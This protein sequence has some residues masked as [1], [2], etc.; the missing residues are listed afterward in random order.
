M[1][2]KY[3]KLGLSQ[4]IRD[5]LESLCLQ[6]TNAG[7]TCG[8]SV[9]RIIIIIFLRFIYLIERERENMNIG[10]QGVEGPEG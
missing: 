8:F 1:V 7:Q 10:K 9:D 4:K 3:L 2:T 6:I 5:L